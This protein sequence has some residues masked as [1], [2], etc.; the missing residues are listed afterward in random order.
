[1]IYKRRYHALFG[2][3][4]RVDVANMIYD[5]SEA[6][7]ETNKMAQDFKNFEFELIRF[8]SM[9]SPVDEAQFASSSAK[10]LAVT[11]YEAAL[12][13]YK[14]KMERNAALAFPIISNVYENPESNYERIV[15]PF[16]DGTK[17][18]KVV[19]NLKDAYELSL[20]HI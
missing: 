16:S 18:L 19:T 14:E 15:V 8:F 20:I 4:L 10:Q 3:R 7:A 13:H 12:K 9:S 17:E 5:T 2:E 11:V 1:M 6:I